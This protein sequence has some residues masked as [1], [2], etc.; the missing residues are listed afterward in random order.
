MKITLLFTIIFLVS[1]LCYSLIDK[2][3]KTKGPLTITKDTSTFLALLIVI[4]HLSDACGDNI[5]TSGYISS[6]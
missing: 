6:I 5:P 3:V 4:C 2:P 1:F